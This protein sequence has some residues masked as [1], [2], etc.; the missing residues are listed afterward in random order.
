MM[1][2]FGIENLYDVTRTDRSLLNHVRHNTDLNRS[3]THWM[4]FGFWEDVSGASTASNEFV[5]ACTKLTTLVGQAAK[6]NSDDMCLDL[7]FGC[8]DQILVWVKT[9]NAKHVTGVEI[10]PSQFEVALEKVD[11]CCVSDRCNLILGSADA[12][13]IPQETFSC[14]LSVDS[15]Y[16]FDRC[17]FQRES[18]R[19]LCKGGRLALTDFVFKSNTEQGFIEMFLL[20]L[21]L[22]ISCIPFANAIS[23]DEYREQLVHNGFTDVIITDISD[24]VFKGFYDFVRSHEKQLTSDGTHSRL[25]FIPFKVISTIMCYASYYHIVRLVCVSATKAG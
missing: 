22:W 16:H 8:G 21:C 5:Y 4:N 2:T 17:L 25:Q 10:N 11:S 18:R 12:L 6:I 24:S 3:P 20:R 9:F 23:E 14:V 19:L 1:S 7:G 13:H 15:A